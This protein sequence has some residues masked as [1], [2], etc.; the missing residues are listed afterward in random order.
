M[1]FPLKKNSLGIKMSREQLKKNTWERIKRN[2][3]YK[4]KFCFILVDHMRE[5]KM[6]GRG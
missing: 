1:S 4:L 3:W 5:G 2:K 6:E